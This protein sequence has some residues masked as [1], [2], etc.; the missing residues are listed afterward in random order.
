MQND[1]TPPLRLVWQ[2]ECNAEREAMLAVLRT[3]AALPTDTPPPG[4]LPSAWR[5][6]LEAAQ[7]VIT[8]AQPVLVETK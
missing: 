8:K 6:A 3:F 1:Y 2:H 4:V 5:A 7:A